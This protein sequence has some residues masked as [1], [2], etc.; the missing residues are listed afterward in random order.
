MGIVPTV[1]PSPSPFVAHFLSPAKPEGSS[2]LP[3]NAFTSTL[4]V[5]RS[6]VVT[7]LTVPWTETSTL[8]SFDA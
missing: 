2:G 4:P 1:T 6:L 5:F 7:V 3:K 8:S